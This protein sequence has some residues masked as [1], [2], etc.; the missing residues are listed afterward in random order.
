M[1]INKIKRIHLFIIL[2]LFD[3]RNNAD[4]QD[5]LFSGVVNIHKQIIPAMPEFISEGFRILYP[6]F[7]GCSVPFNIGKIILSLVIDFIESIKNRI[8]KDYTGGSSGASSSVLSF[9][10]LKNI[11]AIKNNP[12]NIN[13]SKFLIIL[14]V[15]L[16]FIIVVF[17][18]IY[19]K[20]I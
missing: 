2:I 4:I 16:V 15:L 1:Y 8:I 7:F 5:L 18:I 3:F 12:A 10:Q 20:I 19:N 14:K 6:A 13:F 17:S 9:S 11:N